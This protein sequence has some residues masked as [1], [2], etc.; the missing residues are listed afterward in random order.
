MVTLASDAVTLKSVTPNPVR[1]ADA[2]PPLLEITTVPFRVPLVVGV[3]VMLME[4][5]A[6]AAT[7]TGQLLRLGKITGNGN[8]VDLKRRVS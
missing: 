3:K 1:P 2:G 8:S 7:D 5:L 4:Q 6:P